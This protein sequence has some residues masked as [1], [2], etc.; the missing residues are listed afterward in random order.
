MEKFQFAGR[1]AATSIKRLINLSPGRTVPR[2]D[3][4]G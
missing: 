1:T 2:C 4:K 3:D